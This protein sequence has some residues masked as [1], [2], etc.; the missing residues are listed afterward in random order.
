M[1]GLLSFLLTYWC[2]NQFRPF[3]DLENLNGENL[4]PREPSYSGIL[5]FLQ[6]Y[7]KKSSIL[8]I[9]SRV[10]SRLQ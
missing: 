2:V 7:L 5:W 1:L 3:Y 8:F 9:Y 4:G 10:K 6:V